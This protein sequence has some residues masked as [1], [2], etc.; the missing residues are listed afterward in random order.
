MTRTGGAET[1]IET[2]ADQVARERCYPPSAPVATV[3]SSRFPRTPR[4]HLIRDTSQSEVA[5][6][7][8]RSLRSNGKWRSSGARGSARESRYLPIS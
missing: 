6:V 7:C 3:A 1:R 4:C 2:S 8:T 5:T